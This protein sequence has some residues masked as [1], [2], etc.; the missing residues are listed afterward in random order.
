MLN[1]SPFSTP[2]TLRQF[3]RAA[4]QLEFVMSQ[5]ALGFANELQ[6]SIWGFLIT[7]TELVRV[8]RDLQRTKIAEAVAQAHRKQKNRPLRLGEG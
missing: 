1:I 3:N 2:Q 6:R 5:Q 8:K 7:G 4:E